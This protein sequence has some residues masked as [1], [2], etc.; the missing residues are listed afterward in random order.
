MPLFPLGWTPVEAAMAR[1]PCGN[2]WRN[3]LTCDVA[4]NDDDDVSFTDG[5]MRNRLKT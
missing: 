2:D 3:G 4:D 1:S 5:K